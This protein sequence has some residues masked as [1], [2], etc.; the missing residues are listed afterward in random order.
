[1]IFTYALGALLVYGFFRWCL[2]PMV[3]A[4]L[5]LVDPDQGAALSIDLREIAARL[6]R[7]DLEAINHVNHV[8]ARLGLHRID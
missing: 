2:L 6:R 4:I 7:S 8:R 3:E 5:R 1:M